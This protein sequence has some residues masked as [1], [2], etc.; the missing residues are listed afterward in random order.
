[1]QQQNWASSLNFREHQKI[2]S[3][4]KT[5]DSDLLLRL[6]TFFGGGT[7]LV[8][9]LKE[10]CLSLD[11]DFLCYD[12][13]LF[14]YLENVLYKD[15]QKVS[16]ILFLDNIIEATGFAIKFLVEGIKI[17]FLLSEKSRINKSVF[18]FDGLACLSLED[19][20]S[21]KLLALFHRSW[22]GEEKFKDLLDILVITSVTSLSAME[23]A[24]LEIERLYPDIGDVFQKEFHEWVNLT[25]REKK[26][27][28]DEYRFNPEGE[29]MVQEGEKILGGWESRVS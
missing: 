8:L 3:F 20:L 18:L 1:M 24:L 29:K 7:R 10:Y 27:I 23:K 25:E 16:T 26:Q 6:N 11:I 4:L 14:H 5:F 12:F 9:E 19:M 15:P 2:I 28:F 22:T 13:K 21:E 17:E